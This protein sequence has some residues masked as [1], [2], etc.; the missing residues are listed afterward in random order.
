LDI[1]VISR[2]WINSL[3]KNE[4]S[5]PTIPA[6]YLNWLQS[7][8]YLPLLAPP[9]VLHR[10]IEEQIPQNVVEKNLVF[11]IKS[12]FESHVNGE[13]AFEKC[14]I[15]LAR[16]MDKNIISC[17]N[18]RSWKDGGRDAIGIYRIGIGSSYT[19]VEFALEAKC[20]KLSTGCG[21]KATSRLIAR[22]RH[23]QFGI[24]ITTSYVAL[25]AY[26]EI[27]EDGHPVLVLAATDI[28][29]ILIDNGISDEAELS[30]W[31]HQF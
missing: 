17:D 6:I 24:F 9:S 21:V 3:I 12:Y 19:D 26:Q 8:R 13:Y 30:C 14:A 16:M 25:Q 18:T 10:T 28:A 11:A 15:L 7:G 4:D 2:K 5:Y 20:Y 31:L 23:R 29:K 27:I 1:P 22:L